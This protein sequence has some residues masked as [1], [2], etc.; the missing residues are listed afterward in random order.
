M[1]T[2][3]ELA[4]EVWIES[5]GSQSLCALI[6]GDFGWLMFLRWEGDSGFSSRNPDYS[7]PPDAEIA[8]RLNNVQLPN[9]EGVSLS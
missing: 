9:I 3:P 5:L 2:N 1:A 4:S 6:N 7:G 8:Y